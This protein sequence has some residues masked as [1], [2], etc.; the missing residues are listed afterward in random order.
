M[1]LLQNLREYSERA[2]EDLLVRDFIRRNIHIDTAMV[3]KTAKKGY[4]CFGIGS[5]YK[6][7]LNVISGDVMTECNVK[8]LVR[9]Y[10]EERIMKNVINE[11]RRCVG[12]HGVPI[13]VEG[14]KIYLDW[15]KEDLEVKNE[16]NGGDGD[17][18]EHID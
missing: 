7:V 8:G 3:L 10:S 16:E 2:D 17:D 5:F 1:S 6:G 11:I 13:T 18:A 9:V 4:G 12:H 14:A 15:S